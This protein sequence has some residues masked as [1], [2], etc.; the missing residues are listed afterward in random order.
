MMLT[1]KE[2]KILVKEVYKKMKRKP[3]M[4]LGMV[5]DYYRECADFLESGALESQNH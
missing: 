2:K 3:V 5:I 1:E 4:S